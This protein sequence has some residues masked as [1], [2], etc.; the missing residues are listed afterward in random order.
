MPILGTVASQF[1]GKAF[2]SFESI[3][4]VA[5]DSNGL[6]DINFN[7]IPATYAH[8]QLRM[9]LFN[10]SGTNAFVTFNGDTTTNY[11]QHGIESYG[12][13]STSVYGGGNQY[14]GFV[15]NLVLSNTYPGVSILDIFDYQNTSIR[16]VIKGS[17]G[18][19]MNLASPGYS[20]NF[21]SDATWGNTSAITSIN[22]QCQTGVFSQYSTISLY[23]IKG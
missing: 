21:Y 18:T 11:W 5:A 23:G 22:I 6:S 13:G 20:R 3:A 17:Y 15:G 2:G 9:N 14:A 19:N 12:G 10:S 4:T 7:T 16:K 8:L 1:S